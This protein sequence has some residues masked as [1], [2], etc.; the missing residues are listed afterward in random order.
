MD[1]SAIYSSRCR[2]LFRVTSGSSVLS[3]PTPSTVPPTLE[4][5]VDDITNAIEGRSQGGDQLL[6]VSIEVEGSARVAG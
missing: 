6:Q 3:M 1:L 2:S 4:N 5:L